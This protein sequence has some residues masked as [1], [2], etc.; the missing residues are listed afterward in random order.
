[1]YILLANDPRAYREV[2]AAAVRELRPGHQVLA[3]APEELDGAVGSSPPELVLCSCLSALA[4][5]RPLAWVLLYPGGTDQSVI[6]IRGQEQTVIDITF[7]GLLAVID[8]TEQV[9]MTDRGGEHV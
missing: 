5:L 7:D 8:R 9:A 1:M 2:I 3:L 4:K 6:C